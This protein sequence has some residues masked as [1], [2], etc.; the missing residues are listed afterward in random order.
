MPTGVQAGRSVAGYRLLRF[1]GQ[2]SLGTVH[3]A[4]EI[5]TGLPVA[6]KLVP[7]RAGAASARKA[8]LASTEVARGL[9]HPDIVAVHA[10]GVEGHIGWLAMEPVPGT[11]LTRYTRPGRL[12]PEALVLQ[13]GERM[14]RALAYAH[15][16][17]VVH[18][19]LKP[20]NVLVHWPTQTV[21]LADFGLARAA[22]A[23]QTGTGVVLGSPAYMAPE[24]L[25][26]G[27]PTPQGDFYALGVMLFQL[28]AGRL[29]HQG[30]SMG[31]L[32][33]QVASDAAPDLRTLRP[34][35][36]AAVAELVAR[37]LAKR[38]ADRPAEGVA[39]IASL[40]AL[41]AALPA[42]GPKSR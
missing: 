21:K 15:A 32:L 14:A 1:I 35:L 13:V 9:V 23:V 11:D 40:Q 26:G 5:A 34:T 2:G 33:R 20:A 4:E 18:R 31:E 6:L 27:V 8:F 7:L 17:G 24:Q 39:V 37:L 42:G 28:L 3:L 22:D 38:L 36:P 10:V 19:D 30:E 12:L 25:A 41:A 16:Q 29:P